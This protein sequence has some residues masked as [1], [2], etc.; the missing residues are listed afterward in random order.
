MERDPLTTLDAQNV[1]ADRRYIRRALTTAEIERQLAAA[2]GRPLA[3]AQQ[4]RVLKGVTETERARLTALGGARALLYAF[5][6]GTGLRRGELSRMRWAD[7]DLERANVAVPARSAKARKEQTVPLRADLARALKARKG[8]A[9]PEDRVFSGEVFPTR[10]TFRA[11]LEA[12]KIAREDES[13]RIVDF[14]SLRVAFVSGLAAAGVHPRVAQAL[15]RHSTVE[16]TMRTYTDLTLLDTRGAVERLPGTTLPAEAVSLPLSQSAA[17]FLPEL[18]ATGTDDGT[19]TLA[20]TAE[21]A[22][23]ERQGEASGVAP[24]AGLEPATCGLE[25]RCSIRLSY[26]G[27]R[28]QSTA[29]RA[30]SLGGT[31]R[32][33]RRPA[34]AGRASGHLRGGKGESLAASQSTRQTTWK[35][36]GVST[37]FSW[38]FPGSV[39]RIASSMAGMLGS[40]PGA[41]QPR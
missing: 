6:A 21:E 17:P 24:R 1:E 11:D 5:A 37:T 32:L 25:I 16:L 20:Q 8:E 28:G 18:A 39:A 19:G 34:L 33:E 9:V 2:A 35:P 13:G 30:Q 12:A 26:R 40:I 36:K 10:R 4:Q 29:R 41:R 3:L 22:G 7:V 31:P 14:H 27:S 38:I 23:V 15:A